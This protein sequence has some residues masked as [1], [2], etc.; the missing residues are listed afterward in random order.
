MCS[1]PPLM[2]R[3]ISGVAVFTA[4]VKL[5]SSRIP[6]GR[7]G[8]VAV[9]AARVPVDVKTN[10]QAKGGMDQILNDGGALEWV[11][12]YWIYVQE[13][14]KSILNQCFFTDKERGG[15]NRHR[16]GKRGER[17]S[18][19]SSRSGSV[20]V[21]RPRVNCLASDGWCAAGIIHGVDAIHS[22]DQ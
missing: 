16:G 1:V 8:G 4:S 7:A 12:R 22:W 20:F 21:G 2:Y 19:D 15:G 18:R 9:V 14:T 13:V 17:R 5:R 3:L 10:T 11:L 6:W